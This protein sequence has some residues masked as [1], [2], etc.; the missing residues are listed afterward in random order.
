[1]VK[2]ALGLLQDPAYAGP[3]AEFLTAHEHHRH[4]RQKECLVDCLKAF[5]STMKV[6]GA[7]QGWELP[8][9]A[10][11][12]SLIKAM[13]DNN[14]VPA[15][16]QSQMSALKSVLESGVPTLRNKAAGHG[17]GAIP[18]EV[19]DYVAAYALHAT[20]ANIVFLVEAERAL[21]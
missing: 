4:G 8:D 15:Y 11:A 10:T 13:F 7:R 2:P 6:I 21:R 18:T 12:S 14:L 3:N 17:Q 1:V 20:A 5:E 9:K 19:P 16:V